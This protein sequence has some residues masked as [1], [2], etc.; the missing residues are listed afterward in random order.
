MTVRLPPLLAQTLEPLMY[1]AASG[2][3]LACEPSAAQDVLAVFRDEGFADAADIGEI[4]AGPPRVAV[5]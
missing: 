4:V 2:M 5:R 3:A 1:A